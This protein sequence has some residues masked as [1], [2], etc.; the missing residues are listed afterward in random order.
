M[1]SMPVVVVCP[2]LAEWLFCVPASSFK[3]SMFYS[4]S[5]FMCVVW[6]SEQ[7][8]FLL[9]IEMK[10]VYDAVRTVSLNM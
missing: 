10:S 3:N 1:L 9:E 6:I 7:K 2:F 5:V 4:H 8:A